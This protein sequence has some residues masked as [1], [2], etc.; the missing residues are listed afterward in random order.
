[1]FFDF[2]TLEMVFNYTSQI[3]QIRSG[4][5]LRTVGKVA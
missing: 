4:R 5:G 2:S 1:M 3:M